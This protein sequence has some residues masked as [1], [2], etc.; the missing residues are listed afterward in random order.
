MSADDDNLIPEAGSDNSSFS[1]PCSFSKPLLFSGVIK[2]MNFKA[3][4]T[5]DRIFLIAF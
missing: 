4:S 2:S 5:S 3:V 1:L